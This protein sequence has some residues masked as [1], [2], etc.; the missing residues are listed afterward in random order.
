MFLYESAGLVIVFSGASPEVWK[1]NVLPNIMM[2][3]VVFTVVSF[4]NFFLEFY[5]KYFQRYSNLALSYLLFCPNILGGYKAIIQSKYLR[6][7][8]S[9]HELNW[10]EMFEK[11]V[12][13]LGH[14]SSHHE[15]ISRCNFC[16][17]Y[18]GSSKYFTYPDHTFCVEWIIIQKLF[19]SFQKQV[20]DMRNILSPLITKFSA[21]FDKVIVKPNA[22]YVCWIC[23]FQSC[24]CYKHE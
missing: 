5:R 20:A 23:V 10:N 2:A 17:F 6:D 24:R 21:V 16:G 11:G 14:K 9:N 4:D 8:S 13:L 22:K 12:K 7:S 15:S 1:K 18:D 3:L 19:I